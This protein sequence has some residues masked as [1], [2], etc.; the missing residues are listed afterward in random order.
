MLTDKKEAIRN[1]VELNGQRD[2]LHE[3]Y[4]NI[5]YKYY[6]NAIE[7]EKRKKTTT[8]AELSKVLIE[9][10]LLTQKDNQQ[11]IDS[12]NEEITSIRSFIT[13]NSAN[14]NPE[15]AEK[16]A[17]DKYSK[18]KLIKDKVDAIQAL[19][20][21]F[22]DSIEAIEK[23]YALQAHNLK[24]RELLKG[25]E[26]ELSNKSILRDF[27]DSDWLKDYD[28]A[29]TSYQKRLDGLESEIAL[30]EALLKFSDFDNPTSLA[31]WA[32]NRSKE[33]SPEEESVLVQLKDFDCCNS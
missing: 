14:V 30:N 26:N 24:E 28:G 6:S 5:Q 32:I 20:P 16:K 15:D 12:I 11:Q 23:Q 31:N 18:I 19:L 29:L 25:F 10:L 17:L 22:N 13:N 7:E 4:L 1:L 2:E 9:N 27:K 21:K 3:H 33:F 8:D